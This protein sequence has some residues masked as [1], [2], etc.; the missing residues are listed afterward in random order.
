MAGTIL[1]WRRRF[2]VI[3]VCGR[4][5]SNK[6]LGNVLD[7]PVRIDRKWALMIWIMRLAALRRCMPGGGD[8][9]G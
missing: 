5:L 7:T 4:S 8:L 1:D 6:K 2:I 3:S 9:E